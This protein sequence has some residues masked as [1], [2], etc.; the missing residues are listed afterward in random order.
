MKTRKVSDKF[1]LEFYDLDI[2]QISDAELDAAR[3]AQNRHG[4]VFFRDQNLDCDQHIEFARHWGEIVTNRFFEQVEGHDQIAMVRKE[5][6]HKTVVGETWHT[7]HSYDAEPARGSILLAREVPGSGGDTCFANMY[8]AY[9]ALSAGLKATLAGMS[10]VHSSAH[11][12]SDTAIRNTQAE[13]DRFHRGEQAV[14]TSV[15]PVIL[16]HPESGRKALYVNPLFT[17]HFAGWSEE[18]SAPLLDYLCAHATREEFVIQFGWRRDSI[19]FW[20]NRAVM[21]RANNDYPTERRLM[22]RI[23]L[24]GCALH[25]VK[26]LAP[27]AMFPDTGPG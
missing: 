15:H 4:V 14:Q 17:T 1:G 9:D 21:H 16:V 27:S 12:F 25:G 3:Q 10:A 7:D 2:S 11:V 8:L 23:T 19:A 13:E 18:E 24:K 6:K 20:D 22:H 5:P 26:S